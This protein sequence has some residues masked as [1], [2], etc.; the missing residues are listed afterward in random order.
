MKKSILFLLACLAALGQSNQPT[1]LYNY[2]QAGLT[3]DFILDNRSAVNKQLTYVS[4]ACTG[5][6]SWSAQLE[7]SSN[8]TG[9]W[10]LY[11]SS[12]VVDN[13]STT[14]V[15]WG[16]LYNFPNF[17][18]VNFTS[19]SPTCS[20]SGFQR[21]FVNGGS[22]GSISFPISIN[23]GGTGATTA[24]GAR[25]NLGLN[26]TGVY[27]GDGTTPSGVAATSRFQYLR[28]G[29]AIGS[30]NYEFITPEASIS[31][32]YKFAAQTFSATVSSAG[33]YTYDF[34]P[35]P[36]GVSG[37]NAQG[38]AAVNGVANNG[39]GLI[40]IST[41]ADHGL[42]TGDKVTISNVG[43]VPNANGNWVVTVVST[44]AFDLQSSAFSGTYT[45]GGG[46]Y[47]LVH[48]LYV[49]GGSGTA[50]AA[51]VA[52]TST[53]T[54]G[55][56]SGTVV[57]Y[58]S[59]SHSGSYTIESATAGIQEAYFGSPTNTIR[60]P[61]GTHTMY[62]T[63]TVSSKYTGETIYGDGR[64][65]TTLVRAS[66]FPSGNVIA[67]RGI[68]G[69]GRF[70][71]SGFDMEN[72]GNPNIAVTGGAGIS[73]AGN[74]NDNIL[75]N[76]VGIVNGYQGINIDGSVTTIQNT[77]AVVN[78]SY[79]GA[80]S[81][82]ADE[83]VKI[84]N[85]AYVTMLNSRVVHVA[86]LTSGK[87]AVGIYGADGVWIYSNLFSGNYGVSINPTT[88]IQNFIYIYDNVIDII[89][90]H[91]VYFKPGSYG[92]I[93]N[94]YR[95]ENNHI[96]MSSSG[97]STSSG[98]R[99]TSPAEG[100]IIS[101]NNMSGWMGPCITLSD[102]STGLPNGVMI[103]NNMLRDCNQGSNAGTPSIN[104]NPGASNVS[105]V[106][107][108]IYN[109]G[110]TGAYYG[111]SLHTGS[112]FGQYTITGNNIFGMLTLPINVAP[113]IF[114]ESLVISGNGGVDSETLGTLPSAST[115]DVSGR[116]VIGVTGTTTITTIN[117]GHPGR[118]VT[119]WKKDAGT[120]NF[121][122]GGNIV[123]ATTLSQNQYV[124]A[125]WLGVPDGWFIQ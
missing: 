2:W 97:S 123:N 72:G 105:I 20:L 78:P 83:F 13:T 98:I 79:Y 1:P 41:V 6:G 118:E 77:A 94:Q 124:V 44:T 106:G 56:A 62:G 57:L 95:I 109:T 69:R 31:T 110:M 17:V 18:R 10:N 92:A 37:S 70:I 39:S 71:I 59:N 67:Y 45:S 104:I 32:D 88:N 115:I 22:G 108:M 28:R 9:P 5:T 21:L 60:I 116:T 85:N 119:I 47:A 75:I 40:R 24:A 55:A 64:V 121:A 120:I 125:K 74:L 30:V 7:Y 102:A 8:R 48:L 38:I 14:P 117:G 82:Y 15:A 16:F 80:S 46:V 23:Q 90:D 111:V 36:L 96:V 34:A 54:S 61:A 35:C 122:T 86:P 87:A 33:F 114:V 107:N 12:A 53:C 81:T 84:D 50:E 49:S 4:I 103:T 101:G 91:G 73:I 93:H 58:L 99:L 113:S 112:Y 76:D 27:T 100:V 52:G 66:T 51:P 63:L 68:Y 65:R 43:G 11:G 26:L 89:S 29:G 25:T 42:T 3:S 19:G